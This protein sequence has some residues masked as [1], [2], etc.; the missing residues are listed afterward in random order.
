MAVDLGSGLL[1]SLPTL[2]G[3]E[4]G[5]RQLGEFGGLGYLVKNPFMAL[6][7]GW[8]PASDYNVARLRVRGGFKVG[9]RVV[10]D[11]RGLCSAGPGRS[12]LGRVLAS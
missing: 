6:L 11:A 12:R 7:L 10:G 9:M 8:V 1:A 4:D 3:G 2:A 5:G